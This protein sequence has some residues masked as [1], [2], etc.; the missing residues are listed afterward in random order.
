MRSATRSSSLNRTDEPSSARACPLRTPCT[1]SEDS[2]SR[3][4]AR[5][6]GGEHD[7]D[8]LGQQPPGDEGQRQRRRMIEPLRVVD[9]AQQRRSSA[10]SET[11]LSTAKPDQEPVRRGAGA[12]PEHDLERLMLRRRQVRRADR[13]S[14][15]TADAGWRTPAPS[16][17]RPR[18]RARRSCPPPTRPGSCSSAVLPMPASPRS[19][20]DRLLPWRTSRSN[21]S[22]TAHSSARPSSLTPSPDPRARARQNHLKSGHGWLGATHP[23]VRP[24]AAYAEP[25]PAP[26]LGAT[27]T[28]ARRPRPI[29]ERQL[30]DARRHVGSVK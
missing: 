15:C 8:L 14:G 5:L 20:K 7:P 9:H 29:H 28:S 26:D 18:P 3:L 16:R 21:P 24:A 19:T 30:S 27:G 2:R 10:C 25:T 4:V 11:R 6:A 12:Q 22:S 1:S 13:A 23:G 17:T